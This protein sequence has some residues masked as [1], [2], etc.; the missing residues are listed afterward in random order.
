[1]SSAKSRGYKVSVGKGK[2]RK[3]AYQRCIKSLDGLS[4]IID[5]NDKVFIKCNLQLPNGFPTNTSFETLKHVIES[6]KSAGAAEIMVGDF[7][8]DGISLKKM[9]DLLGIDNFL[10]EIG[11]SLAFLDNSQHFRSDDLEP[12]QLKLIKDREFKE[13]TQNGETYLYPKVVLN[14][15]KLIVLNQ[16]NVDPVF[17][18]RYALASTISLI[19]NEQQKVIN[20]KDDNEEYLQK[21]EYKRKLISKIIDVHSIKPPDLVI[22]DCFYIMEGAGPYIYEKSKLK[23][24]NLVMAGT[25]A[26]SLD[27]V[28]LNLFGLEVFE[29]QLITECQENQL[30]PSDLSD[31]ELLGAISEIE[32]NKI[33]I[34][35]PVTRAE[36]VNL[37]NLSIKEGSLCSGCKKSLYHLLNLI[38]S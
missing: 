25:N 8:Y 7:P 21:D 34:F 1:M 4:N 9:D 33:D 30:G 16:V 19:S 36:L 12:E 32:H 14:A 5:K 31:I 35:P 3:E 22:N 17:K 26:L 24:T 2:T 23:K 29:H 38:D 28:L 13:I 11:A 6:C 18:V 37:I 15:D 27:L 20:P 10:R